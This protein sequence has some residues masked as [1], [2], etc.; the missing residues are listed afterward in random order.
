MVSELRQIEH[1][2]NSIDSVLAKEVMFPEKE[3]LA[4]DN[5]AKSQGPDYTETTDTDGTSGSDVVMH[6]KS[7]KH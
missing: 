2:W 1:S 6:L 5:D 4:K 7:Y 3:V